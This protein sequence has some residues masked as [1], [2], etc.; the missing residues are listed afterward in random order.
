MSDILT[1]PASLSESPRGGRWWHLVVGVVCMSMIANLQYGWTL[2]VN[3]IA[4]KYGWA[5]P[6]ILVAFTIFVL[7]ETWLIPIEGWFVDKYGPRIVVLGASRSEEH[8]S[9]LQSRQYL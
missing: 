9:E 3:P 4:D 5:K 1:S 6:A 2:F 7:V 8:T